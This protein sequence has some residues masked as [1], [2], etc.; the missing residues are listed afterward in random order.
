MTSISNNYKIFRQRVDRFDVRQT[1]LTQNNKL[2][3]DEIE[4]LYLDKLDA[5]LYTLQRISL[6]LADICCNAIPGSRNRAIKLLQMRTGNGK[7][8][9]HLVP[10]LFFNFTFLGK[11]FHRYFYFDLDNR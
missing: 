6:I 3:D 2:S 8:S 7:L 5:G 1:N 9:K 4:Q 10:V 11:F